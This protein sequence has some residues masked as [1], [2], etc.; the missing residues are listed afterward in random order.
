LWTKS[1]KYTWKQN[2]KY[3]QIS[4][5]LT[6]LGGAVVNQLRCLLESKKQIAWSKYINDI[7]KSARKDPLDLLFVLKLELEKEQEVLANRILNNDG[8]VQ[9]TSNYSFEKIDGNIKGFKVSSFG[10]ISNPESLLS[11]PSLI[12]TLPNLPKFYES[13]DMYLRSRSE[14]VQCIL[15]SID[16][17][18]EDNSS[19]K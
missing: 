8:T 11:Q 1:E 15:R 19:L 4:I 6:P 18:R 2:K 13:F 14:A 9:E 10:E 16:S 12:K 7:I 5:G 3:D 17:A